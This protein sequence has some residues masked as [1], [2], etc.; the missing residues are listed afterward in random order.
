M[1]NANSP[2]PDTYSV[3]LDPV[4]PYYGGFLSGYAVPTD[5]EHR[6]SQLM[7]SGEFSCREEAER[8]LLELD[9]ESE[10]EH[11]AFWK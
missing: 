8:Y 9:E 11:R 1:Y 6:V 3:G 2:T 5:R 10:A 4:L 7:T